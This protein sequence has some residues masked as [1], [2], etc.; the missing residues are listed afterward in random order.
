[1]AMDHVV[2]GPPDARAEID[3]HPDLARM[4][5]AADLQ[6]GQRL[7]VIKFLAYGWS[8][9]RSTHAIRDQVRA[10]LAEAQHTGWD[11]LVAQQRD[12]L[13]RFWDRADIEV[14][15]DVELQQAIRFAMFHTLQAGARAEQRAIAAKGLTGPGYDGHAFWDTEMFVLP[16][17]TYTH[18]R[19]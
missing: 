9:Q 15:G 14:E 17:L 1:A 10:A 12:Y 13:D 5:I 18:P 16:V 8:G 6:P 3:S 19:A 4:L 7:R 2:D 11:G